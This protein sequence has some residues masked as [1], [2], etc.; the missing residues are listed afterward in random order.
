MQCLFETQ[1]APPWKQFDFF[2]ERRTRQNN[3]RL[4]V[5]SVDNSKTSPQF[6]Y[7]EVF[8]LSTPVTNY[9]TYLCVS[10]RTRVVKLK[11]AIVYMEIFRLRQHFANIRRISTETCCYDSKQIFKRI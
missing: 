10:K 1:P 5:T 3:V 2:P 9:L 7:I 4:G 6:P 11:K 8:E